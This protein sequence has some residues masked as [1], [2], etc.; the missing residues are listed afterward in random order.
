MTYTPKDKSASGL[1]RWVSEGCPPL[2]ASAGTGSGTQPQVSLAN[3]VDARPGCPPQTMLSG[4]E[5]RK[6][7]QGLPCPLGSVPAISSPARRAVASVGCFRHRLVLT[8]AGGVVLECG[9]QGAK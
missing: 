6:L 2:W 3:R 1:G 7:P 9:W 8:Q 5:T 4:Q